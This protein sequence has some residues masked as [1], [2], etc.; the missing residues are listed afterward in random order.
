M[1]KQIILLSLGALLLTACDTQPANTYKPAPAIGGQVS[2][3]EEPQFLMP[4]QQSAPVT[5][6]NSST[7]LNPEHGQPGH[8]C[9]IPVGAPLN[10]PASGPSEI[11]T[12]VNTGQIPAPATAQPNATLE[13]PAS[14]ASPSTSNKKLNPEHGQ[15]GHDCA[16]PVGSPLP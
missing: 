5:P 16:V 6:T 3:E 8:R 11:T 4:E 2:T 7:A 15:P 10:T 14:A 13:L 12:Q 9:E 1:L